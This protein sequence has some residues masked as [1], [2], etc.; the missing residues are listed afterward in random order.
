[1]RG[2]MQIKKPWAGP[3][4]G[5]GGVRKTCGNFAEMWQ[6]RKLCGDFQGKKIEIF[7]PEGLENNNNKKQLSFLG[8]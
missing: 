5:V 4:A 8:I 6:M 7:P 2:I 3:K 1:M